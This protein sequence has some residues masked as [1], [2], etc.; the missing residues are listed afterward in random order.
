M[1][2]VKYITKAYELKCKKN[3]NIGKAFFFYY[4]YIYKI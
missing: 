2:I 3:N 4:I 1:N